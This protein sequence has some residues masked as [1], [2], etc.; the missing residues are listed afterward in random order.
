MYTLDETESCLIGRKEGGEGKDRFR[1]F[2]LP[3]TRVKRGIGF[4]ELSLKR[5]DVLAMID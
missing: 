4:W 3:G 1:G 5:R 2:F